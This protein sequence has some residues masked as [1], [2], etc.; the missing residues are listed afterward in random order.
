MIVNDKRILIIEYNQGG[1]GSGQCVLHSTGRCRLGS[2]A[3]SDDAAI[4]INM[5]ISMRLCCSLNHN[6]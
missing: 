3:G 4:L 5:R 2:A 1:G 6:L